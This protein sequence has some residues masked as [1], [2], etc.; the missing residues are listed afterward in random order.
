[1]TLDPN[2]VRTHAVR[3]TLFAPTTLR[4][5]I[6]RLGFVQADP[7]RAPARAQDLIL[8]LRVAGYRA[9]D[10]ERRYPALNIEE[11]F[12]YAYGFLLRPL[13]QLRHPPNR[14]RLTA[15]ERRMLAAVEEIGAVH[16]QDLKKQFGNTR[17]VNAWGG[18]SARTKLAL[19]RLHA[20]GLVR[21]ARRE[22]GIR[23]YE[24]CPP[25]SD[26]PPASEVFRA[27][28]FA[29]LALLAPAPERS[30]SAVL[31]YLRHRLRYALPTRRVLHALLET[32]ELESGTLDG[33][34]YYWPTSTSRTPRESTS[35]ER[36]HF[37]AP[38]DPLVWDR[39]R[40]EQLYGW[41]YRF[42]AYTP[43]HKRV[44]GYYAMPL[45]WRDEVIGWGNVKR[46][47]AGIDAELGFVSARPRERAF[48]RGLEA[49]LEH[50]RAF[51]LKDT[52][53]G[54]SVALPRTAKS[55]AKRA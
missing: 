43:V 47:G 33:V 5:A 26:L 14:A 35:G 53:E 6:A 42:E 27:L 20:R 32:G 51:L 54:D 52:S 45:L 19:E 49:E 15:F 1:V 2:R 34:R 46:A 23:V 25:P 37:L 28:V 30:L 38:F 3:Q 4:R 24:P 9:G 22:Q 48:E 8:R 55:A 16:P 7:I 39:R 50:M 13:W 17:A 41:A 40:F 29:V 10:L 36:L 12:L 11:G 44:R 18:Y 31:A 21:V